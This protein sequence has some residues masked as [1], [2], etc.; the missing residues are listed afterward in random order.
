MCAVTKLGAILKAILLPSG[1]HA[2][3]FAKEPLVS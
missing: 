1:D 3:A 2:G